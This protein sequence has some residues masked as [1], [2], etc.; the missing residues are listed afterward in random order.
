MG[1]RDRRRT[2]GEAED[3]VKSSQDPKELEEAKF[4]LAS[5]YLE[6]ARPLQ[7]YP[8]LVAIQGSTSNEERKIG[9]RDFLGLSVEDERT[10]T[11]ERG[12]LCGDVD[13]VRNSLRVWRPHHGL[14]LLH[15]GR[16]VN[17]EV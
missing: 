15:E 10:P 9:A 4:K 2:G 5:F 8:I 14:G 16:R 6:E 7:A 3:G 1:V 17:G 13:P 11:G 12:E